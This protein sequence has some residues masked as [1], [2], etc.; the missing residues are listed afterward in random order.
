M[1]KTNIA[2]TMLCLAACFAAADTKITWLA[3]VTA[4]RAETVTGVQSNAIAA[5][6]AHINRTDN[7]HSVTAAQI[8]ALTDEL[9]P[10]ANAA[11]AAHTN[12][13]DNPHGVTAAQVGAITAEADLAALRTHHYGSPDIVESPAE[14]FTFDGAGTIT[15]YSFEAGRENVV[16]PWAIGGVPVTAI[17]GSAFEFRDITSLIA[18]K[19]VMA[20]GDYTFSYCGSLTSVSLPQVTSI[21]DHVFSGCSSLTSLNLPQI[22]SIGNYAFYSC[23]SLTTI[24]LP[25]VTS[26]GDSAFFFCLTLTSVHAGQNAPAEAGGVFADITPP[27]TVYVTD[28]QATGWGAVWNGAPVVRPPLYG[29]NVTAQAFTLGGDT[30]TEWPAGGAGEKSIIAPLYES[31]T[32]VTVTST[33]SVYSVA[34]TGAG[35][36]GI[37]WSGLALDGTGRAE[38]TLRLNVTEWG[39]TNVTFSPLLT[40]DR[41]PEILVTGVWEFA[42]STVDGVATR[43]RQTWPECCAWEPVV[44]SAAGVSLIVGAWWQMPVA[45]TNYVYWQALQQA[46]LVRMQLNVANNNAVDVNLYAAYAVAGNTTFSALD[47]FQSKTLSFPQYSPGAYTVSFAVPQP[48]TYGVKIWVAPVGEAVSIRNLKRRDFNA[49][50]RAAYEAGWRP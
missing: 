4:D 36:V 34:V 38:V 7:P 32:N 37:D 46:G 1:K 24:N 5:A 15:W 40:F 3:D 43:V 6:A 49:N 31:G 18:P 30:I 42:A 47:V 10:V 9:D 14:W 29:S 35:P 39:G 48:P 12:R 19:T 22:T 27:P 13:T 8:G 33:Q 28:P 11:L 41:T 50:E 44:I 45:A 20:I 23:T 16:I 21:G 17:G 25:Q 2:V 26:I